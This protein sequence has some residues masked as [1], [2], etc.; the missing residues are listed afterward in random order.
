M[1][2]QSPL[3]LFTFFMVENSPSEVL[4]L[5]TQARGLPVHICEK[6]HLCAL[7]VEIQKNQVVLPREESIMRRSNIHT[8]RKVTDLF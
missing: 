2:I 5:Q 8:K 7:V 4:S 1:D 6:L 3:T